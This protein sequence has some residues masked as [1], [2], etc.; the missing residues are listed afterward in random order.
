MEGSA[1]AAE[2]EEKKTLKVERKKKKKKKKN[3]IR[4]LSRTTQYHEVRKE[5]HFITCLLEFQDRKDKET[6]RVWLGFLHLLLE[7]TK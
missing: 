5:H 4:N 2:K 6:A 7:R 3:Y 1:A